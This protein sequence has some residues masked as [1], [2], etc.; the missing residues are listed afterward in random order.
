MG[1]VSW[2]L[3]AL[4][5]ATNLAWW[6]ALEPEMDRTRD[7]ASDVADLRAQVERLEAER[8]AE[9]VHATLEGRAPDDAPETPKREPEPRREPAAA[10]A[11]PQPRQPPHV[12]ETRRAAEQ[13]KQWRAD[14]LQIEDPARREAALRAFEDAMR[15]RDEVLATAALRTIHSLRDAAYDKSR[16]RDAVRSRLEDESD[17]VRRA[18]VFAMTGVDPEPSDA[19]RVVRVA[20]AYPEDTGTLIVGAWLSNSRIE[21]PLADLYVKA[22]QTEDAREAKN[23]ANQLRGMW[24]TAEVEQA[25]IDAYRRT[26]ARSPGLWFHILGQFRPTRE[27]RVRLIFDILKEAD[28]DA[29]QLLNRALEED[30]L[31]PSAVPLAADLALELL[32]SAPNVLTR[33]LCLHVL[34]QSGTSAHADGLRAFAENPMVD[35]KLREQAAEVL[36]RLERR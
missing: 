33:R 13:V 6:L 30:N 2:I 21:G 28:Y 36:G 19:D 12:E 16:F 18:A 1:R 31:D 11:R 23:I 22:L 17:N 14:V 24:V 7:L 29:P 3:L 4:L 26:A 5:V 27:S 10:P 9:P 35:E 34:D 15:S 25:A 32:P 20:E 8:E